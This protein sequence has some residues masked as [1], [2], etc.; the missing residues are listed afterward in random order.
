MA[1]N[2]PTSRRRCRRLSAEPLE[3]RIVLD[4]TVVFSEIMYNPPGADE[5][6]EW[7]ELHNQMAVNVDISGWRL[8]DAVEYTF[9]AVVFFKSP[10]VGQW[11]ASNDT[12][13]AAARIRAA[14]DI[15]HIRAKSGKK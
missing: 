10:S 6:L 2:S 9:E 4:S 11:K 5:S 15:I 13:L 3:P 7:I 1:I 12:V 8:D 14:P